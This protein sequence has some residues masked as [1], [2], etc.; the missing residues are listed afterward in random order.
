MPFQIPFFSRSSQ[1]SPVV[2]A[3]GRSTVPHS[4]AGCSAAPDFKFIN[5]LLDDLRW[6]NGSSVALKVGLERFAKAAVGFPENGDFDAAVTQAIASYS[7]H[8]RRLIAKALASA[9]DPLRSVSQDLQNTPYHGDKELRLHAA[10][11]VEALKQAGVRLS[12][13]LKTVAD[14]ASEPDLT[15]DAAISFDPRSYQQLLNDF[16]GGVL[17]NVDQST[18]F[19]RFERLLAGGEAKVA[20]TMTEVELDAYHASIEL[21]MARLDKASLERVLYWFE[22]QSVELSERTPAIA[23]GAAPARPTARTPLLALCRRDEDYAA[24]ELA[25]LRNIAQ[26]V[27]TRT[28]Q[29]PLGHAQLRDLANRLTVFASAASSTGHVEQASTVDRE[30]AASLLPDLADVATK[31]DHYERAWLTVAPED[32]ARRLQKCHR[33]LSA[34]LRCA[35]QSGHPSTVDKAMTLVR[36]AAPILARLTDLAISRLQ[37][38]S[39]SS[40]GNA[41]WQAEVEA[42]AIKIQRAVTDADKQIVSESESELK[43]L[44]PEAQVDSVP[45]LVARLGSGSADER[46]RASAEVDSLVRLIERVATIAGASEEARQVLPMFYMRVAM[47]L[48]MSGHLLN[49]DQLRRLSRCEDIGMPM[50]KLCNFARMHRDQLRLCFE[51]A[52]PREF[53]TAMANA[54]RAGMRLISD[55]LCHGGTHTVGA[56]R[57]IAFERSGSMMAKA[58]GEITARFGKRE[59][60]RVY[61]RLQA[62]EF[63]ALHHVLHRLVSASPYDLSTDAGLRLPI[64]ALPDVHVLAGMHEAIRTLQGDTARVTGK[65]PSAPRSISEAR[66]DEVTSFLCG[67]GKVLDPSQFWELE[68]PDAG[69]GDAA[70]MVSTGAKMAEP[71]GGQEPPALDRTRSREATRRV[72][73]PSWEDSWNAEDEVSI[74]DEDPNWV[75]PDATHDDQMRSGIGEALRDVVD[76]SHQAV[77]DGLGALTQWERRAHRP[78]SNMLMEGRNRDVYVALQVLSTALQRIDTSILRPADRKVIQDAI[79]NDKW[80]LDGFA[81]VARTLTTVSQFNAQYLDKAEDQSILNQV[82]ASTKALNDVI[83]LIDKKRPKGPND[84]GFRFRNAGSVMTLG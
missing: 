31:V 56:A 68:A 74:H 44:I 52:T 7:N 27:A 45:P 81:E 66:W 34:I 28:A 72:P 71:A 4:A 51:A 55:T 14:K 59:L 30:R 38:P 18:L 41:Q 50:R 61:A 6:A 24:R 77:A 73:M 3:T 36:T 46:E 23:N 40:G 2:S 75:H 29:A 80:T 13:L 37:Q 8:Q 21:T 60:G 64:D 42:H 17:S 19:A 12:S 58:M 16:V 84:F 69:A 70:K 47:L 67:S 78:A 20:T 26:Q 54:V 5:D 83:K 1:P 25:K 76:A 10:A 48:R 35:A 53:A 57:D 9:A 15:R 79:Q 63:Q 49:D 32:A 11:R 43:D 62:P 39:T 33:S 22:K 82:K 65:S